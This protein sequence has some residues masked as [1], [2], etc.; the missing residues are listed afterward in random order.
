MLERLSGIKK[1]S[2]R[3][4]A[5]PLPEGFRPRGA[6]PDAAPH[7]VVDRHYTLSPGSG[8]RPTPVSVPVLRKTVRASI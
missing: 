6:R 8:H 1:N 4:K 7:P 2:A 5:P 3:L